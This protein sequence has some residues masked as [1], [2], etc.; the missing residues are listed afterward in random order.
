MDGWLFYDPLSK[1]LKS[2]MLCLRWAPCVRDKMSK[3]QGLVSFICGSE[4]G[5]LA[6]GSE[7][8]HILLQIPCT[9]TK[10][11]NGET[12]F[13]IKDR[14]SWIN[15]GTDAQGVGDNLAL[16][17]FFQQSCVQH[18]IPISP[19][20]VKFTPLRNLVS[21][22]CLFS[23]SFDITLTQILTLSVNSVGGR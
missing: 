14:C 1:S 7:G 17:Y 8:V 23:C 20:P 19:C 5:Q 21:F 6:S 3:R 22:S 18:F 4:E 9:W 15:E 16:T 2:V 10:E 12:E 11:R 13:S